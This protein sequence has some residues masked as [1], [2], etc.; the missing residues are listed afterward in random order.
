MHNADKPQ[1][2]GFK[3]N[4]PKR[5]DEPDGRAFYREKFFRK[6]PVLPLLSPHRKGGFSPQL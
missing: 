6:P 3:T 5:I 2:K 1:P 4:V